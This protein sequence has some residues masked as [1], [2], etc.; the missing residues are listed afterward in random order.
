[1][2]EARANERAHYR[3]LGRS[4]SESG[5]VAASADD[6]DFSYPADAFASAASLRRT[7]AALESLQLGAYLGAV[8]RT[9][10]GAAPWHRRAHRRE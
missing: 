1:M 7:G 9:L 6:V 2:A 4:S 3:G 8:R 10:L 5:Q